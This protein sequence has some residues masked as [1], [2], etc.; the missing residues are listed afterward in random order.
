MDLPDDIRRDID[1]SPDR[2]TILEV[3]A[4]LQGDGVTIT[5]DVLAAILATIETTEGVVE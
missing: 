3:V 4:R 1:Q 5:R 2:E